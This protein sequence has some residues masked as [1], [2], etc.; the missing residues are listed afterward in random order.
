MNTIYETI[1]HEEHEAPDFDDAETLQWIRDQLDRGNE[2]AWFCA[3]VRASVVFVDTETGEETIYS[4]S[5]FLGGCSYKSRADFEQDEPGH[6]YHDMKHRALEALKAELQKQ[7]K[8]G[9]IAA[10]CME[11]FK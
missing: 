9:E 3:E 6:Y 1:W 11:A 8:R 10:A 4:G 7:I 5:D 2:W